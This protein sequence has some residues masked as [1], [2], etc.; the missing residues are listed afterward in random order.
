MTV[1][2]GHPVPSGVKNS[3]LLYNE[4]IVYDIAQVKLQF[5]LKVH[6]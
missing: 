1:P 4:Y 2:C 5:S 6:F 3:E